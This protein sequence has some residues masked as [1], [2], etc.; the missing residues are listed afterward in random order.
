MKSQIIQK[1][2]DD[3]QKMI[4]R[5]KNERTNFENTPQP[6]EKKEKFENDKINGVMEDMCIYGNMTKNEILNEKQNNPK[7]F[8]PM[9][10]A[11]NKEQ[12][13]PGLFALALMASDLKK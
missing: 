13:E 2:E 1:N 5:Q 4:K 8:I 11:L 7:K 3:F 10:V 9:E 6:P 12:Q